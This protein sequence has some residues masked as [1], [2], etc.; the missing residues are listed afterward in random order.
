ML[1]RPVTLVFKVHNNQEA[2]AWSMRILETSET[3]KTQKKGKLHQVDVEGSRLSARV[4]VY[5]YVSFDEKSITEISEKLEKDNAEKESLESIPISQVKN[6]LFVVVCSDEEDDI[7]NLQYFFLLKQWIV[8]SYE[9]NNEDIGLYVKAK[10]DLNQ[11]KTNSLFFKASHFLGN[12]MGNSCY[13]DYTKVK[14][15]KKILHLKVD[16]SVHLTKFSSLNRV[17]SSDDIGVEYWQQSVESFIGRCARKGFCLEEID[18]P[19]I[20]NADRRNFM[21]SKDRWEKKKK[22]YEKNGAESSEYKAVSEKVRELRD[23]IDN[24]EETLVRIKKIYVENQHYRLLISMIS[25]FCTHQVGIA[26]KRMEFVKKKQFLKAVSEMSLLSFYLLCLFE[27]HSDFRTDYDREPDKLNRIIM[28]MRD[29]GDGFGQLLQNV[30]EH[31]E[32]RKGF[33]FVRIHDKKDRHYLNNKYKE[34]MEKENESYIR[35]VYLELEV[36]DF[37]KKN[38]PDKFVDNLRNRKECAEKEDKEKYEELIRRKD[39]IKVSTF[40]ESDF[41]GNDFWDKYYRIGDNI[42]YHYGLQMFNSVIKSNGGCFLAISTSDYQI[43]DTEKCVYCSFSESIAESYRGALHIP[44]TQY[45]ILFP[46]DYT[47]KIEYTAVNADIEY[48]NMLVEKFKTFPLNISE[49]DIERNTGTLEEKKREVI[50]KL[51]DLLVSKIEGLIQADCMVESKPVFYYKI[52]DNVENVRYIEIFCKVLIRFVIKRPSDEDVYIAILN[53]SDKF[54]VE[55][56]RMLTV[57]YNKWEQSQ[58]LK[59]LQIYL[60]GKKPEHAFLFAGQNIAAVLNRAEKLAIARGIQLDCINILTEMLQRKSLTKR[61]NDM[62]LFSVVPFELLQYGNNKILFNEILNNILENDICRM[63]TGCKIPNTHVRL[64]SKLHLKEFY[65]AELLFQNNYFT[66]RFAYLVVDDIA[67]RIG[68]IENLVLVGYETYSEMLIYEIKELLYRKHHINV[69]YLIYEQ[70]GGER[71]RYIQ[72]LK[73]DVSYNFLYIVPINSTLTTH[74]KMQGALKRFHPGKDAVPVAKGNYAII[75]LCPDET[76]NVERDKEHEKIKKEYKWTKM[77]NN[78]VVSE[79]VEGGTVRYFFRKEI[80]WYDAL[81]CECCFPKNYLMEK[82]LIETNRASIIPMQKF[83]LYEEENDNTLETE[84]TIEN[85]ERIKALSEFLVYSHVERNGNHFNYYFQ[86]GKFFAKNREKIVSWLEKCKIT[87]GTSY[88]RIV[89]D[90]IVAPQHYSN[91]GFVEEVNR[92]VFQNASLVLDIEVNKEFRSNVR[93]KYSNLLLL[94]NNLV[95]CN[96]QAEICFHFVDDTIITGTTFYR[97]KSLIRS[98]FPKKLSERVKIIIFKSVFL[99]LNRASSYSK[100]NYCSENYF[101]YVNL[102]ISSMRTQEDACVLCNIVKEAEILQKRSATDTMSQYWEQRKIHHICHNTKEVEEQDSV[103]KERGRRRMICSHHANIV[104]S[105]KIKN[106]GDVNEVKSCIIKEFLLYKP[107]GEKELD[108]EWM[109]SYVKVLSRPFFSFS[110]VIRQAMFEIMLEMLDYILELPDKK[111]QTGELSEIFKCI[112][113]LYKMKEKRLIY[114]LFFTLIKRLSDLGATYIIRRDIIEKILNFYNVIKDGDNDEKFQLKYRA[115]IKKL[116]SISGD[117]IKG[118]WLEHLLLFGKEYEEGGQK[119]EIVLGEAGEFYLNMYME[120]NR[121]FVDA[122]EDLTKECRAELDKKA[123]DGRITMNDIMV[124]N[125]YAEVENNYYYKNFK[126]IFDWNF[127]EIGVEILNH[128]CNLY[129]YLLYGTHVS[130]DIVTYYMNLA[131]LLE[132]ATSAEQAQIIL[133]DGHCDYYVIG[134][135]SNTAPS[136]VIGSLREV[137]DN[138]VVFERENYYLKKE[139]VGLLKFSNV[140]CS[141]TIYFGFQFS[142]DKESLKSRLIRNVLIFRDKIMQKFEEDFTTD[143][144]QQFLMTENQKQRLADNRAIDHSYA[145]TTR[146]FLKKSMSI[147]DSWIEKQ[148]NEK[149]PIY[150]EIVKSSKDQTGFLY[151]IVAHTVMARIFQ[152]AIM[153]NL[154]GSSDWRGYY[155]IY[156]NNTV[157]NMIEEINLYERKDSARRREERLRQYEIEI[158]PEDREKFKD[159]YLYQAGDFELSSIF[160]MLINNAGTH[161]EN[162]GMKVSICLKESSE[163]HPKSYLVFKNIWR[164]DKTEEKINRIR[165]NIHKTTHDRSQGITLWTINRYLRYIGRNATEIKEEQEIKVFCTEEGDDKYF[166]IGIPV[167]KKQEQLL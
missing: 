38:V 96:R 141:K 88:D 164:E 134:D 3:L 158:L 6:I 4:Y 107:E 124:K 47:E 56:T 157:L 138:N 132:K 108:F 95:K 91:N 26:R 58:Q 20:L 145:K 153:G 111:S 99:V 146:D 74:N 1:N 57:F 37:S 19:V 121:V 152:K 160:L 139:E 11:E 5:P 125:R 67:I 44:G 89:F 46:L 128:I 75:L 90:V 7:V 84:D 8:N 43:K 76:G 70:K 103:Q 140:G 110:V 24:I 162:D 127:E 62:P 9:M 31:S 92:C 32:Y 129:N 144:I 10:E 21:Q 36:A 25:L 54:I 117:E 29:I 119:K 49:E 83:Q 63:P 18:I 109:L 112:Y 122:I 161:G 40:F 59:N 135:S 61:N 66:T 131:R 85:D 12:V 97:A 68:K 154:D 22:E 17:V 147:T 14:G 72:E 69:D 101:S 126:K 167:F 151:F 163:N 16:N 155:P 65:Q 116:T 42:V 23:K 123:K 27:Y 48:T 143:V 81:N 156:L 50:I 133:P 34:Y 82:P 80:N 94:Y 114:V 78:E 45:S 118:T 55:M 142:G 93:A 33:F 98:I 60:S 149:D 15:P 52:P 106:K 86:M 64:G 30:V 51:S 166:N 13:G 2:Y 28:T 115:C 120:N 39:D 73:E 130:S 148:R 104:L 35:S 150:D 105:T 41:S 87:G 79:M 136:A 100:L 77:S 102:E 159:Y 165:E 137:L 53:C 113:K 71:F